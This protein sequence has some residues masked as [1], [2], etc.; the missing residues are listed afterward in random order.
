MV[1]IRLSRVGK[2]KHPTYRIVVSDKRKDTVGPFL[3]QL[4][5]YDP[6]APTESAAK[7]NADRV[8][9]WLSVGATASPSVHNLLVAAKLLDA[10]PVPLGKARANGAA[11]GEA[12]PAEKPAESANA[13]P[14][15]E[16]PNKEESRPAA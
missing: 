11:V 12:A 5:T 4:G 3:E 7:L 16:K 10:K 1:T 8:R 2:R 15:A 13:E 9:H 14:P 6:H